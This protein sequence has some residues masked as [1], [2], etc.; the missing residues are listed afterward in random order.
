MT[1]KEKIVLAMCDDVVHYP[2]DFL[3]FI[4]FGDLAIY[5]LFY[6][7]LAHFFHKMG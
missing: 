6:I 7:E 5:Y 1:F 3:E 2:L 4:D